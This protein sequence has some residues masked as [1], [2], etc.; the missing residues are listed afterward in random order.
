MWLLRHFIIYIAILALPVV[1]FADHTSAVVSSV[2]TSSGGTATVDW[3]LSK[4]VKASDGMILSV[5]K[6]DGT[7]VAK[8]RVTA[9]S[10]AQKSFQVSARGGEK[11]IFTLTDKAGEEH[12]SAQTKTVTAPGSSS[13]ATGSN[14]TVAADDGCLKFEETLFGTV[15][16]PEYVQKFY[17]WAVSIAILGAVGGLIY[18]GYVYMISGGNPSKITNAKESIVS[19]LVGLTLLLLSYTI[20]RFIGINLT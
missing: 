6:S 3:K 15:C 11:L 18:A 7:E 19:V 4:K 8:V 14:V 12:G 5:K 20:L 9:N 17:Y 10:L 2:E 16:A 1:V 13:S